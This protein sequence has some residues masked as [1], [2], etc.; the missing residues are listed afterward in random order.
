[1]QGKP[2]DR[3][4]EA[5]LDTLREEARKTGTVGDRGV[6]IVG[7]PIPRD[8]AAG[9][10]YYGQPIVKPP[11]WT[12]QI[13]LYFFVGGTA[14]MGGVIALAGLVTGQP[15]DFVR[16]ALGMAFAG[17][18][19]SP[20]L[21]IADL[22]RPTRFLN[23]LR[24]FKWRSAMSMGVWTLLLFGGFAASA[25][26]LTEAAGLLTHLGVSP[27]AQRGVALI[28]A[29]GTALFG[30]LL[31]TYTGVLLGA[32]AIPAWSAHH[33]LL[34]FHFG[35]VALGSAVAVLELLGYRMAALNA[36]GVTVAAVET[37]VGGWMEFH[38]KD[39]TARAL[40]AG[41]AGRLL[42][43]AALMTGPVALLLRL[44]GRVPIAAVC[45]LLGAVLSR[46]GWLSA[47]RLSALDPGEA[48]AAQRA[49]S[50]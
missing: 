24:V 26:L 31:A 29:I 45:F 17:A 25:L 27:I 46:Y 47:G 44:V 8:A 32:T 18:V 38:R 1:V 4:T 5:R 50:G 40:H 30:A 10:G 34:P 28:L 2:P 33:R 22:G 48:L 7:G 43:T 35:V 14:G 21:L 12:W 39:A 41:T 49:R 42:R 15:I 16:A 11:V 23:M 20:F 19:I 3:A 13:G 9:S 37:A 6:A 36:I